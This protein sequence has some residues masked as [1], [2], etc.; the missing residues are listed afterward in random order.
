MLGLFAGYTTSVLGSFFHDEDGLTESWI[1]IYSEGFTDNPNLFG[2]SSFEEYRGYIYASVGTKGSGAEIWR[3]TDYVHWENIA[4]NGFGNP[5]NTVINLH[6]ANSRLYAGTHNE[7]EGAEIWVSDDGV[8]FTKLVSKGLGDRDNIGTSGLVVFRDKILVSVQN[9]QVNNIRDGA[10]IWV[11]EDGETFVRSQRGGFG[12]PSNII[13][14]FHATPFKNHLYAGTK[15]HVTGG[16][17]WRTEDGVKWEKVVDKGFGDRENT[18]VY[19]LIIFRDHFYAGTYNL[20]GLNVYRSRDGV[21]WEKVV[22]NG[23]NYGRYRNVFGL[24]SEI[25]GALYLHTGSTPTIGAFQLWRS[26]DGGNWTQIGMSGFGNGNNHLSSMFKASDGQFYLVTVN[27][28]DGSE[29]WKSNDTEKWKMIFKDNITTPGRVSRDL[30]EVNRYLY[31]LLEDPHDGV[32]IWRYETPLVTL[33]TITTTAPQTTTSPTHTETQATTTQA[34]QT[35]AQPTTTQQTTT[36]VTITPQTVT[37]TYTI[38]AATAESGW[39]VTEYA[40]IGSVAA[41]AAVLL[42]VILRLKF[43]S[44]PPPPPPP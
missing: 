28:I 13:I 35:T 7:V 40:V 41:V 25:D 18:D 6:V 31:L 15:N 34:T 9:G 42:Y 38:T 5:N 8:K 20:N 29:V 14:H 33:T 1:R 12:N 2:I 17:L 24:F 36:T 30:R 4:K 16:E 3:T 32:K 22:A 10:E 19:P 23:F 11:S 26:Y 21:N 44:R 27:G 37:T 43:I 39:G